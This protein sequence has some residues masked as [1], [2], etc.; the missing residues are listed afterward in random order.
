MKVKDIGDIDKDLEDIDKRYGNKNE[1]VQ[2]I[3]R[4]I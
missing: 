3:Q 1:K 2:I 4:L